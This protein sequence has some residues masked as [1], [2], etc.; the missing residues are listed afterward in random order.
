MSSGSPN[1]PVLLF[2]SSAIS[3]DLEACCLTTLTPPLLEAATDFV[4]LL[5][6]GGGGRRSGEECDLIEFSKMVME[7]N[8]ATQQNPLFLPQRLASF[9]L[10]LIPKSLQSSPASHFLSHFPSDLLANPVCSVSNLIIS[11]PFHFFNSSTTNLF[12]LLL[13]FVSHSG[14]ESSESCCYPSQRGKVS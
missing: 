3:S 8:E 2:S 11:L 12:P 14:T 9:L 10:L 7:I 1:E 6:G 13:D 5:G 4:N